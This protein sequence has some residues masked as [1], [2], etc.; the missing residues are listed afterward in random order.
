MD[1]PG[2]SLRCQVKALS[3]GQDPV[4][5]VHHKQKTILKA[6]TTSHFLL[7]QFVEIIANHGFRSLLPRCAFSSFDQFVP[8]VAEAPSRLIP[9]D[10]T[11][12]QTPMAS[13]HL[14]DI[15]EEN[16]LFLFLFCFLEWFFLFSQ[17]VR[18]LPIS[19]P[20]HDSSSS[21]S[22]SPLKRYIS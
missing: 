3:N 4:R 15:I 17:H 8:Q 22:T 20:P 21:G 13:T 10:V 2:E 19:S 7:S 14:G 9:R 6:R 12:M 5:S 1:R 16:F 18:K 11:W